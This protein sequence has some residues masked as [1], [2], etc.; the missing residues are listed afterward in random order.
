MHLAGARD[1]PALAGVSHALE[2]AA[3]HFAGL[4]IIKIRPGLATDT[5][6]AALAS[7]PW[8]RTFIHINKEQSANY[9]VCIGAQCSSTS[10]N[11]TEALADVVNF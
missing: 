6:Q 10:D 9:Q 3:T 1:D 11:L 8:R 7:M 2:A 4:V 5:L